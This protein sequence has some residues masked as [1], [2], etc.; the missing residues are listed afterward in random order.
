MQ[1]KWPKEDNL[2]AI[3]NLLVMLKMELKQR[4]HCYLILQAMSKRMKAI[5]VPTRWKFHLL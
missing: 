4:V 1:L 5:V 2:K 3:T